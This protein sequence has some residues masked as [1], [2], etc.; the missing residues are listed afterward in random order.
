MGRLGFTVALS[1]AGIAGACAG[2]VAM[3]GFGCL[4]FYLYLATL[5]APGLA[6]LIV[7]VFALFFA[8]F[9]V[10]LV[11]L[12]P[13]PNLIGLLLQEGQSFGHLGDALEIGKNLGDEG[14]AFIKANLSGASTA[15]F[16]FG[17]AMGISPKLRKAVLNLLKH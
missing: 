3:I 7:A 8:G 16:G 13:R 12:I 9:M 5:M 10:A 17:I 6:A 2:V 1:L 11:S 4:A 15:A 14:R